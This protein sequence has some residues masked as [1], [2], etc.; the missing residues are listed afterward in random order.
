MC[1]K[2]GLNI[3]NQFQFF[4][5]F[6]RAGYEGSNHLA[7]VFITNVIY[8]IKNLIL[9]FRYLHTRLP[10][11]AF[12]LMN[13]FHSIFYGNTCAPTLYFYMLNCNVLQLSI[14]LVNTFI[15]GS[16]KWES[17]VGDPLLVSLLLDV[18]LGRW[19]KRVC[20]FPTEMRDIRRL[21]YYTSDRC[22]KDVCNCNCDSVLLLL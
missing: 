11:K 20:G 17:I 2:K 7:Q 21:V 18:H 3:N 22:R 6:M 5:R 12:K 16:V 4:Y 1:L 13:L 19:K 9:Q 15:F 10:K 14:G 8:W